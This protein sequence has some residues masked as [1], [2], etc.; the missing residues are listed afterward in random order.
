VEKL[1][2]RLRELNIKLEVADPVRAKLAVDGYHPTYGARPLRREI[3]RQIENPLSMRIVNGEFKPGDRVMVE[4]EGQEIVLR[5]AT[6]PT[7]A[8]EPEPAAAGDGKSKR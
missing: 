4:L 8:P 2:K 3:E 7:S 6:S 5:K 1:A